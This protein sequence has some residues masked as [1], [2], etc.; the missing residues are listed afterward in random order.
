MQERKLASIRTIKEIKPIKGADRIVCAVVDGWELVTQKS[1]DLKVGDFVV[2]FEID[3][4]LPQVEQFEFLH[5]YYVTE[6]NSI[7]GA[8]FRLKTIRLRGQVSQGLIIPVEKGEVFDLVDGIWY[9]FNVP[10]EGH[11]TPIFDGM[12]LTDRMGVKKYEKPIAANLA[13][14]V[15]GNF[16]SFIP[17]TDEERI[18]NCIGKFHHEWNNHQFEVT[19][20]L[21]GS[22]FT[23]YFIPASETHP[24]E[25]FGVCSRNM[26]LLE[27]EGNSFWQV[28]RRL[29]LENKLR[30]F[31]R[32][33]AIQGEL[34]GPG[35]QGNREK[36]DHLQ[37]F[38][39]NIY[40]ITRSRYLDAVERKSITAELGMRHV[41]V[42][43]E[44]SVFS[45]FLTT[46]DFLQYAERPSLNHEQAEG[47]VF[48]SLD[49][50]EIS[51]KAIS[52]KYLLDE[53]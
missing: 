10:S 2:Y 1:N 46:K 16:P 51:F 35:V 12:D 4:L 47:I 14:I 45:G 29:D 9:A 21:D 52:N 34:M 22:S 33:I 8:G 3:S 26:D 5:P 15:R 44:G 23:A 43:D 36:L 28:V 41:P 18:Q 7:N 11:I 53:D 38:V 40:D 49:N 25:R 13:G 39:F 37:V 31:D 17:K 50:P 27:S 20:K 48:K 24:V 19:L 42:I 32:S 30:R 6:K